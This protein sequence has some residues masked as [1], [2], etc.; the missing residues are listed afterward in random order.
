MQFN[1]MVRRG[2]EADVL[3]YTHLIATM[4]RAGME[5]QAYKLFSRMIEQKI[6][7]LPE[8]YLALLEATS[9][10]RKSL[11][12]DI[13]AKIEERITTLPET[14]AEAERERLRR[15]D[16]VCLEKFEE[17]LRGEGRALRG[18]EEDEQKEKD[19]R[20]E[21]EAL[22]TPPPSIS[23]SGS[24]A[25][26][27]WSRGGSSAGGDEEDGGRRTPPPPPPLG[28]VHIR[29]PRDVWNIS[30]LVEQLDAT[31]QRLVR[32]EDATTRLHRQLE[33]L[34][35]EELRIF[36]TIHRQLRHG[37][38]HALIDR[39]LNTVGE[40]SIAAMLRRRSHYFRSV[41]S[42]LAS[43]LRV[44]MGDTQQQNGGDGETMT[45]AGPDKEKENEI[46]QHSG[47][48]PSSSTSSC[49]SVLDTTTSATEKFATG[50]KILYTPWGFLRR[51]AVLPP[52]SSTSSNP[53]D[54]KDGNGDGL[55]SSPNFERLLR[56]RLNEEEMVLLRSRAEAGELDEVPEQLLRRYAYQ[57]RLR[58]RRRGGDAA[59]SLLS[60]VSWHLTTFFAL[61][62]EEEEG[63]MV[64]VVPAMPDATP[65]LRRQRERE[66]MAKT[67]ENY[68]AF[69]V[70]AQRT[71]NLQV[72][73]SKEINLHLH[74]VR[75][76]EEKRRRALAE[77]KRVEEHLM[78]AQS[79][80]IAATQFDSSSPLPSFGDDGDPTPTWWTP[81]DAGGEGG[82]GRPSQVLGWEAAADGEGSF[83]LSSS[84]I[85]NSDTSDAAVTTGSREAVVAAK[86]EDDTTAS[87][88]VEEL[89]P[90]E[91][92]AGEEEF[93]LATGRFGS[94]EMG[95]H[96]ELSDSNIRLLPNR[97]A[98]REW[99]VDRELLP[100]SLHH[101]V[102]ETTLRQE[103]QWEAV[104]AEYRRRSQYTSYRKW[105]RL[106]HRNKAK[107]EAARRQR[108]EEEGTKG[109]V[110]PRKRFAQL[111]RRG[112]DQQRVSCA[113][114]EKYN[115]ST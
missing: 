50:P 22:V 57:F 41:E 58:W 82:G 38:K 75:R 114:R 28:T 69:R 18:G 113:L 89:P 91:L 55:S 48:S 1:L 56:V 35:E 103:S 24:R 104:E 51:P 4:G 115:R 37:N 87:A 31:Q 81:A 111:L 8:T 80:A 98:E 25:E 6:S 77:A 53:Y 71:Q 99:R 45:S 100:T 83:P 62:V 32:G 105:D 27:S 68:D 39:V 59:M 65:A 21:E 49:S 107:K 19:K 88:P 63:A 52:S 23:S 106:L 112:A 10:A 20:E 34:D 64:R 92:T 86:K 17:S 40:A 14:L 85:S 72:V 43:D 30:Q 7:P 76:E 101:K 93:D 94:P 95:R 108:E 102:K 12:E 26:K 29:H 11:R 46:Q 42:I 2:I 96:R 60:V 3:T 84:P 67:L 13:Q 47:K 44:L 61:K 5:W 79:L 74:K 109:P 33:K 66:G 36:L 97:E 73:D 16:A 78:N 70:I 54:V 90:W 9:P 110:G 15:E